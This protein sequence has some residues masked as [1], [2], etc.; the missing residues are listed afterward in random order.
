MLMP[1][2]GW[3]VGGTIQNVIGGIDHWIAF[4]LLTFIGSKMLYDSGRDEDPKKSV[5]QLSSLLVLSI[6]TSIDALM[7]GL[8][9]AFLQTNILTPILVIGAIT[10]TLSLIGFIFG[11]VLGEGLGKRVK[12]FGGVILMIIGIQ[13]LLEDLF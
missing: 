4:G 7:V 2:I 6:A 3:L 11:Y 1:L 12:L 10:F 13:I 8:S 9:F 5:I